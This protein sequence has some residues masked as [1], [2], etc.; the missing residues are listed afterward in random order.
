MR[1]EERDT[2][3][4]VSFVLLLC[5]L[6]GYKPYDL[7]LIYTGTPRYKPLLLHLPRGINPPAARSPSSVYPEPSPY[8][9]ASPTFRTVQNQLPLSYPRSTISSSN[10]FPSLLSS[11]SSSHSLCM[12]GCVQAGACVGL[13]FWGVQRRRRRPGG[14]QRRTGTHGPWTQKCIPKTKNQNA[15]VHVAVALVRHQ[16]RPRVDA[17]G[18][19]LH[20]G[21]GRIIRALACRVAVAAGPILLR[22]SGRPR[23]GGGGSSLFRS[24]GRHSGRPDGGGRGRGGGECLEG[25]RGVFGLHLEGHQLVLAV[26]SF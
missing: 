1:S 16:L 11:A 9:S 26:E 18:H 7:H 3:F 15:P 8:N 12:G 13:C 19:G 24:S 23:V 20:D 25:L 10:S 2:C 6:I 17:R 14:E 21:R 4:F 22:S 5:L